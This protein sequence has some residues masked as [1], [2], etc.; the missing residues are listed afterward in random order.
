MKVMTSQALE[1]NKNMGETTHFMGFGVSCFKGQSPK[2]HVM[3]N[4]SPFQALLYP[5]MRRQHTT[6]VLALFMVG[7]QITIGNLSM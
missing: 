5:R 3:C 7:K 2:S 4:P 1:V 6:F